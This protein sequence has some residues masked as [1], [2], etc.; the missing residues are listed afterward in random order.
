VIV[1][2]QYLCCLIA[3]PKSPIFY[4]GITHAI[5]ETIP[6][7]GK[8]GQVSVLHC[9]LL[10][11]LGHIYSPAQ[12]IYFVLQTLRIYFSMVT[13]FFPYIQT[14]TPLYTFTIYT[15]TVYKYTCSVYKILCFF[16]SFNISKF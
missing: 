16:D 8:L 1:D 9:L 13:L 4:L 6:V 5:T 11:K 3:D 2:T 15:Y 14:N 7:V 10:L 12:F